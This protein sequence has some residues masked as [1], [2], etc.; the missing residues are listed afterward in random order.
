MHLHCVIILFSKEVE[1]EVAVDMEVAE[2]VT[3]KD[4]CKRSV[5]LRFGYLRMS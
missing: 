4:F 2:I 3:E 1:E 5:I